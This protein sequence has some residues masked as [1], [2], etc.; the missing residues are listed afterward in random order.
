MPNREKRPEMSG[1]LR[2]R[3]LLADDVRQR[4]DM[5]ASEP[6]RTALPL[7]PLPA[8]RDRVQAQVDRE[9]DAPAGAGP[10][11]APEPPA[12]AERA[13][14]YSAEQVA[15]RVY[16]LLRQDLRLERQRS[17]LSTR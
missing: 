3:R 8:G 6:P 17:G 2:R 11:N 7:A 5:H 14:R 16:E 13:R 12:E 9:N 4:H 10:G 15:D 1:L